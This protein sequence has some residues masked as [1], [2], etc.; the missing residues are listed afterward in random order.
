LLFCLLI[1]F[2]FC[3]SFSFSLV[4][5][6]FGFIEWFVCIAVITLSFAD[7]RK[8]LDLFPCS[9]HFSRKKVNEI[10]NVNSFVC[11]LFKYAM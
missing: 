9:Y 3:F 4:F 7:A 1:N 11:G 5:F 8:F 6:F 2:S 10:N